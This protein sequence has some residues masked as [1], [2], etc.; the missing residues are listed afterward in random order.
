MP[1]LGTPYAQAPVVGILYDATAGQDYCNGKLAITQPN[2][3]CPSLKECLHLDDVLAAVAASPACVAP[4]VLD[5]G[6]AV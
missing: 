6:K 1:G 3:P 4:V 2:D 5:T